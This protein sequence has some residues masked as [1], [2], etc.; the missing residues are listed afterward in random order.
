MGIPVIVSAC[1]TPIGRFQGGLSPLSAPKLGALAVA[2]AVRRAG[3]DS[4]AVDEVLM[5]TVLQAGQGQNPARQAALGGGIPDSVA[6]TTINKVC[7]SG[8]ETVMRAA[9]AIKAGDSEICVAG[10]MESMTNA[11]YTL[12]QARAGQRL[13]NGQ[14]VDSLVADG[15][16]DVYED[17][18]MGMTAELVASEYGVTREQQ[19]VWAAQSQE[20]AVAAQNAG[21]FDAELFSV[22][23]PGRIPPFHQQC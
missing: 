7:G 21:K 11:P 19:D 4:A 22:E 8:L 6:A 3:V 5:G 18:H 16:W 12:P 23:V 20:R 2:E 15:L 10:G 14:L 9:Q 13:G 17:F 1:R